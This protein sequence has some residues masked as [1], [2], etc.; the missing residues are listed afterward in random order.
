VEEQSCWLRTSVEGQSLTVTGG[1]DWTVQNLAYLDPLLGGLEFDKFSHV[2]MDVAGLTALDTAG[3][4]IIHR[5]MNELDRDGIEAVLSG[6]AVAYRPLLEIV[7]E[8]DDQPHEPLHEESHFILAMFERV[9]RALIDALIEAKSLVNFFGLTIIAFG[10][11]IAKPRRLRPIALI[12]QIEQT[13]FNAVLIVCLLNFLIGIVIA[14]QGAVQLRQFGAEI[15]MIDGLAF[16]IPREI[17]VLITAI[18]VAGRSGSAFTAQIGTMQVNQEVDALKVVGLDPIEVLVLP[19]INALLITL[20]MLVFLADV[21]GLMGGGLMAVLALD[22]TVG[23]FMNRLEDV[24]SLQH[25]LVGLVKAPVFAY[26]IAIVGCF[27]GL[28]VTGSAESVGKMTTKSVV[29]SIVLVILADALFSI[30]FS[31]LGI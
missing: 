21:A 4:H 26:I 12:N 29:E 13:G 1:G 3:A 10:S 27:E 14:Y 19:R 30:L 24:I 6:L 8:A 23:Q 17:A 28:R 31:A 11:A 15:F 2:T 18:V 16:G 7:A 22:L 25:F 9:G 20:P 5:L